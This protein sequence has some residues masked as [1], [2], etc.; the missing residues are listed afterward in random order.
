MIDHLLRD[1]R[2]LRKADL[3]IGKIWLNVLLRRFGLVAFT[4]LI[5]VF[6]LGMANVAGFYALQASVGPVWAAAIIA[7]I[8]IVIAAV[9]LLVAGKSHPGPELDLT[10]QVRNMAVESIETDARDFKLAL[11]AL[12]EEVKNV[13]AS[14][15]QLVQHPLYTAAQKLLI[16]AALSVLR[17]MGDDMSEITGCKWA[18]KV[19]VGAAGKTST[20]GYVNGVAR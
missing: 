13:R 12:G 18:V 9:V 3:L 15:T 17:G 14:I 6:G 2:V 8:D 5:A 11:D 7:L 19:Q 10:F 1:L 4:G 16:P 20:K